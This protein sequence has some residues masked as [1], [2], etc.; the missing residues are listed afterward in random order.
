MQAKNEAT[1][2]FGG[3]RL[4][5]R[6][7]LAQVLPLSQP[8]ERGAARRGTRCCGGVRAVPTQANAPPGCGERIRPLLCLW[9]AR[10]VRP[11]L[12]RTALPGRFG[13]GERDDAQ[14]LA[15]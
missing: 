12:R 3:T 11:P 1:M 9:H 8:W 10:C 14:P 13:V 7:C 2:M 6:H 15:R 4:L 5:F